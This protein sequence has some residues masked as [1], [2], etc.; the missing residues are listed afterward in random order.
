MKKKLL[1]VLSAAMVTSCSLSPS[2]I[3][4]TAEQEAVNAAAKELET[5]GGEMQT[6]MSGGDF[7]GC[8][9]RL[10][11][12][13]NE[14]IEN[15]GGGLK[16]NID[17]YGC[18]TLSGDC[19]AYDDWDVIPWES[20]KNGIKTAKVSVTGITYLGE[21]FAGCSNLV[22]VDFSGTD[23]SNVT[24]M[25]EMFEACENLKEVD[26][27]GFNTSNV[28][29][30]RDMFTGCNGLIKIDLSNFDTSKVDDMSHMFDGCRS[31][32]D[33]NLRSF[34]TS[35]VTDMGNMF[36]SCGNLTKI[37]LSNFDTSKVDDMSH[38]FDGCRSLT[39]VNLRSFDTSNVADMGDMFS[40]CGNLTKIDLSNF[41]TSKVDDM[42]GMFSW[43]RSLTDINVNGFDTSN[44]VDMSSMFADCGQL[45]VIDLNSF[46]T[47][48][49]TDMKNM[50]SNC[51]SLIELDLSSFNLQSLT[52]A[53]GLF[54]NCWLQNIKTPYNLTIDI[55]L[56][57]LGTQGF[58]Q[59]I[60][61]QGNV[62]NSLPVNQNAGINLTLK[63]PDNIPGVT[64]RMIT[65]DGGLIKI[66]V[67]LGEYKADDLG[68]SLQLLG[69]SNH[70]CNMTELKGDTII[71]SPLAG[72]ESCDREQR[73]TKAG[74]YRLKVGFYSKDNSIGN[75]S[76][77]VFTLMIPAD[78]EMWNVTPEKVKYDG[79]QDVTFSFENGTNYYELQSIGKIE[80]FLSKQGGNPVMTKGFT[81]D[82][83][84]GRVTIE[85]K[86][87]RQALLEY[88]EKTGWKMEARMLYVGV[89]AGTRGSEEI[90]FNIVDS[91]EVGHR[92]IAI[93][94]TL[95]FVGLKAPT[96]QQKKVQRIKTA[97]SGVVKK[98]VGTKVVQTAAGAQTKITFKSS[99]PE[100]A[101]VNRTSG[102][103]TCVGV[104]KTVITLKAE[105]SNEYKAASKKVTIYVIPKTAGI[106]SL[107]SGKKG[108][109]TVKSTINAKGNDGYQIQYKHNGK[110]KTVKI[111][112]KKAV[113]R[114]FKKLRSGKDF[115]VRLRAYKKNGGVVYYGNYC[116]WKALK[117]VR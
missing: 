38:M 31:L 30:M 2:V 101:T 94:W 19:S 95:D 74:E 50:F 39:D 72:Y 116:K 21:L 108:Q 26:L 67:E 57:K 81:Y 99:N 104:G 5:G 77:D 36:S 65:W 87:I 68:V 56:P 83:E 82:M 48:K 97:Y 7:E 71:F 4:K 114:T 14:K 55:V 92:T 49:V 52:N 84:A 47:S 112:A 12:Q 17:E 106:K 1:W 18:F 9:Q 23:T 60:D 54:D 6:P 73:W 58:R 10:D 61:E 85:K 29:N 27:S 43:C 93:A 113:T 34:D 111:P 59:G 80:L 41:D 88:A 117:R 75:V 11:E 96:D 115:K 66:P 33:I 86:A 42:G 69:E 40:S 15:Q 22:S 46:N 98:Q 20:Q 51:A 102:V 89:Y 79:S 103:I 110:T 62:Y 64:Q 44:V 105:E 53:D 13:K 90:R 35:N 3:A 37:D 32:T 16:W 8:N 24:G 76:E 28:T 25:N 91:E 70:S 78:S 63:N 109:V 100:A 45:T 107:K